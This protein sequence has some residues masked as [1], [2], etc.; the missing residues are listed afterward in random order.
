MA[1]KPKK[2]TKGDKI[3]SMTDRELAEFVDSIEREAYRQGYEAYKLCKFGKP[4]IDF[5]ET[6][7]GSPEEEDVSV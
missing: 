3:R 7:F 4:N 5:Y 1:I 2:M 6:F